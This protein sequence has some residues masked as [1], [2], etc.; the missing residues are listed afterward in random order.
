MIRAQGYYKLASGFR[1]YAGLA[2]FLHLL[3]FVRIGTR[4]REA[5]LD[6]LSGTLR[7]RDPWAESRVRGVGLGF[8]K[9]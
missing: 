2:A 3:F 6:K 8:I 1:V 5:G 4:S 7:C 9:V